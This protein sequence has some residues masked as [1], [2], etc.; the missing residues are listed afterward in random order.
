MSKLLLSVPTYLRST[1]IP[2]YQNGPLSY[3]DTPLPVV[4]FSHGLVGNMNIHSAIL[5][6]LASQGIFCVAV[7]HRDGSGALSLVRDSES[8]Q[9]AGVP[10]KTTSVYFKNV[11]LK[12]KPGVY[13]E[14]DRQLQIRI[15]ELMAAFRALEMLNAGDPLH[16]LAS[17]NLIV[18]KGALNLDPGAVTWAGHSLGGTT[19]IQMSIKCRERVGK[20][21]RQR[22]TCFYN[23]H[24]PPLLSRSLHP[25][26]LCCLIRGSCP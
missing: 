7:E 9:T 19:L 3:E 23:A 2:V 26:P 25:L 15:F 21:H 17:D 18:P 16:N 1:I 20:K 22:Q 4:I 13:E 10:T 8:K 24:P 14:R 6:E 11:S 5:G 12:I